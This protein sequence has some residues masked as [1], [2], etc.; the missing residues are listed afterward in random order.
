VQPPVHYLPSS[1]G[2]V[3]AARL[4]LGWCLAPEALIKDAVA[5]GHVVVLDPDRPINVPLYWQH[6]GVRS[7]MLQAM[8]RALVEAAKA[9]MN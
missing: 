4:G 1:I 5:S 8:A 9:G 6:A 7:A 3:D 2:F